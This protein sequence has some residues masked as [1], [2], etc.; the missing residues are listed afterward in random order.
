MQK[1]ERS[2]IKTITLGCR[3]NFYESE[4]SRA[5]IDNLNTNDDIVIINTCSVTHEAERQ[6]KQ[7]VRKAIRENKNSKIIVT[8]CAAKTSKDYFESLDGVFKVIQN[9]D[10][11][12]INAYLNIPQPNSNIDLIEDI[13]AAQNQIFE[14]R[15]RAF[16][17]IQNGCDHFCSYCIVPFTRGRSHSLPLENILKRVGF[18]LENGFSELVLSGIDITSYGKDLDYRIELAD[19]I[20]AILKNY[21]NQ[22]RLRISSIDPKGISEKLLELL[23]YEKRIMPHFHLS[24]QS[25]DNQVLKAMKRRHTREDI[26]AFCKQIKL[27]R[28]DV[29]FGADFIAGFPTETDSMFQ[30]TLSLID[31]AELSLMHIFPFSSRKETLASKM[32]QLPQPVISERAR[33]LREKAC[34][35]KLKLFESMKGKKIRGIIEKTIDNVSYGKTDSFLPFVIKKAYNSSEIVNVLEIISYNENYLITKKNDN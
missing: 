25:G 21:P 8:G 13:T 5:I 23:K 4:I 17:Q 15:A 11:E 18:F 29:V 30:N 22:K 20:E 6:S 26:I 19:V 14:D 28:N 32:V 12:N 24:I 34:E 9:N 35:A 27:T 10:K 7:A 1:N 16:I 2:K 33:L 3:F 31:E